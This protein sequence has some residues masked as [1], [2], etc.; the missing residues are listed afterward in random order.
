MRRLGAL[1]GRL[2]LDFRS[3]MKLD[4]SSPSWMSFLS[5]FSIDFASEN[6]SPNL[7]NS[8]NSIGKTLLFSYQ[9]ILTKNLLRI[10]FWCQLAS[11]LA[12]QI[13]QNRVL[14]A[15]WGRL[16]ASW[17][18][19]ERLGD[20]LGASWSALERLRAVLDRLGSVLGASWAVLEAP[21]E[22]QPPPT[23]QQLS[24]P[25]RLGGGR[26][27]VNPPPGSEDWRDCVW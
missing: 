9:A 12:P 26:G 16:G 17:G 13:H 20:V 8:L 3:K 22:G 27:R 10:R 4:R 15:S 25:S 7:I 19:W 14:E 2:G 18:V 11:V 1:W 24:G 5:R 21:G 6:H 23:C